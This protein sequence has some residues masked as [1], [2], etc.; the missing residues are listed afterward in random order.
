MFLVKGLAWDRL[1]KVLGG[2]FCFWH[3]FSIWIGCGRCGKEILFLIVFWK[4]DKVGKAVGEKDK[5]QKKK[6]LAALF[7]FGR[8]GSGGIGKADEII[9]TDLIIDGQFF[10]DGDGH[11]EFAGFIIRIGGLRHAAQ[12]GQLFLF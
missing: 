3:S 11:A 5:R 12:L 9:D 1:K 2:E 6:A 10:Q 7:C 4:K 8:I